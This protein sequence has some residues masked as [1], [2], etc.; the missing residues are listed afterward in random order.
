MGESECPCMRDAIGCPGP[1]G[2]IRYHSPYK[3]NQAA[4]GTEER[5][6]VLSNLQNP[7]VVQDAASGVSALRA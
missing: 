2:K 6:L 4:G 5:N 3:A 7:H 1:H